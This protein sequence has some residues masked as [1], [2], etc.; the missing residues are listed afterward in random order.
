MNNTAFLAIIDVRDHC[1]LFQGLVNQIQLINYIFHFFDTIKS[2]IDN[3]IKFSL[4]DSNSLFM[5]C[6]QNPTYAVNESIYL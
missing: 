1:K 2:Y 4:N 6:L 5:R 3:E